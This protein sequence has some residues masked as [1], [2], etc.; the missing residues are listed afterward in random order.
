[1]SKAE[2]GPPDLVVI[3]HVTRDLAPDG[4]KIGG[5]AAY[6][7]VVAARLGLR[8]ALVTCAGP[9]MDLV[10]ALAGIEVTL[11]EH[12]QTTVI[13]HAFQAGRRIQY[14]RR[15]AGMIGRTA[16]PRELSTARMLIL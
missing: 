12:D 1:M 9:D 14:V 7:S 5:A 16:V 3:G 11:A 6:A 13:E 15:R 10:D 8:T 2:P 4:Y